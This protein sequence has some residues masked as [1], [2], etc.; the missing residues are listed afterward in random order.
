MQTHTQAR[1]HGPRR[2]TLLITGLVVIGSCLTMSASPVRS[3]A[4]T[5]FVSSSGQDTNDCRTA[6][7]P[8]ATIGAAIG[9][10]G[11]GDTIRI[12]P[13]T[14]GERLLISKDLIVIGAGS[15]VTALDG[16]SGQPP[17]TAPLIMVSAGRVVISG[18]SLQNNHTTGVGAGLSNPAG[19]VQLINSAVTNNATSS[20]GAGISNYGTLSLISTTV[21]G[22]T[23]QMA[24]GG[25]WNVGSLTLL[26]SSIVNNHAL[27]AQAGGIVNGG[28]M[29][30]TQSIIAGNSAPHGAAG[31]DSGGSATSAA[32]VLIISSTISGNGGAGVQIVGVGTIIASTLSGNTGPGLVS[33]G[34]PSF[35]PSTVSIVNSTLSGNGGGLYNDGAQVSVWGS[36]I[37]GNRAV[38]HNAGG[39]MEKSGTMSLM[40]T[41]I[42]GNTPG[43]GGSADCAGVVL[44]RGFNVVGDPSGC[45][46]FSNGVMGDQ[47]GTAT[48]PLDPRLGVLGDNGGPT[49]TRALLQG[50][51]AKDR[52][53]CL[54]PAGGRRTTDQR[55]MARPSPRGGHC[56]VGAYEATPATP[57]T[58]PRRP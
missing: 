48:R 11:A 27:F 58:T 41:I 20:S 4:S 5:W 47:V 36:T 19:T 3:A 49:W 33:Y 13:G 50:S 55:G 25:I 10:G 51:P 21:T 22:G 42:A 29:T 43:D 37:S 30:V 12:G 7:T 14:Y 6:V 9:K 28:S 46:G 34:V 15:G 52:G 32:P 54:T 35:V 24:G 57:R 53:S 44:S 31:L 17:R 38:Y 2:R 40:T 39:L 45:M 18:L 56:D 16:G 1:R 8:C 26:R 23:A